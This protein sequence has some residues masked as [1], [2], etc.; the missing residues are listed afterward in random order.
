MSKILISL[1]LCLLTIA[2]KPQTIADLT[3]Q[4]LLDKEKLASLK[5]TLQE[6]YSGYKNLEKG[7]T[8]VRDIARANFS[9]HQLFLDGL[10]VL[11]PG[12][13]SD[14]RIQEILDA[15][16]QIVAGSKTALTRVRG[17][18]VFTAQELDYITATLSGVLQHCLQAVEELTMVISDHQL[19]MSDAQRLQVIGRIHTEVRGQYNFLQQFSN[20]LAVQAAQR[21]KQAGDINALKQLYGLPH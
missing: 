15:E 13:R 20:S 16:Y 21:Q 19:Q 9:L 7:Y 14:A 2:G 4:L 1:T 3:E 12:V 8:R 10:W 5:T 18:S 17:S 6:M 11:S